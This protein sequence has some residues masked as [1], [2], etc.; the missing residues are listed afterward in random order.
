MGVLAFGTGQCPYP[1]GLQKLDQRVLS[2]LPEHTKNT[3][4][5]PKSEA[6]LFRLQVEDAE[7]P[8]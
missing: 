4:R 7:V 3:G 1:Q 6:A 5:L 8:T 2:G